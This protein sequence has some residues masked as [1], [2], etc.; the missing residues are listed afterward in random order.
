MK[1]WFSRLLTTLGLI[2]LSSAAVA[3]DPAVVA[4][5]AA[6]A[7]KVS[8]TPWMTAPFKDMD[9]NT[10]TLAEAFPGKAIVVVNTASKCGYTPQY[11]DLEG[12]YK[13]YK[14][15]GLV[16]VGFP[17]N[18]FG[19]QE[20]GTDKEILEFCTSN[21]S[22]TFPMMSKLVT[23]GDTQSP[24]YKELTTGAPV[25]GD[26]RWNFEKFVIG[27]D[28]KIVGRFRSNVAPNSDEFLVSVH[29]ALEEKK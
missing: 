11:E 20:P 26:I 28:G 15:K 13:Q 5:P 10:K 8:A 29:T 16:V 19:N 25:S 22:V 14:D 27:R 17:A 21:F 1:R 6:S 24:L 7:S 2:G 3:E 18:D 4:P 12:L 23:K 9:G